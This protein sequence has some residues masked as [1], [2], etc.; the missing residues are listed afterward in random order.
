MEID[1][2]FLCSLISIV[3]QHLRSARYFIS[4]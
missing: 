2:V 1:S 4:V 3:F